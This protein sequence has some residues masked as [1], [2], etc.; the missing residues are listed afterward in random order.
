MQQ[1]WSYE[2]ETRERIRANLAVY[3]RC[4]EAPEGLKP[5]AVSVIL[6][7]TEDHRDTAF[8]LTRR[9]PR[10]N[11][12]S[13]QYAL[14]GG[15]I[16]AGETAL[17]AARL[18]LHEEL[19]IEAG[20]AQVL[21]R[22]DNLPTTSG[23]LVAPFVIWLGAHAEPTP[24]P[25]EI[26]AV[27]RIPLADLFAGPGRGGNRGVAGADDDGRGAFSRY[28]PILGQDLFAPTAAILFHFCEVALRGRPTPPPRYREPPFARR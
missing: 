9:A 6:A 7:P 8:L 26:A 12:H 11:A 14:P 27:H 13:G 17:D 24:S 3:P 22:L 23:Y 2:E 18:E 10:L 15:R 19:G 28:I 5:A 25:H 1:R 16:D 21:G 4:A 20:P